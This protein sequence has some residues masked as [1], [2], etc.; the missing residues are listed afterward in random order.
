MRTANNRKR[1]AVQHGAASASAVQLDFK[2][3][4]LRATEVAAM[5][6]CCKAQAY[7]LMRTGEIPTV[8]LGRSV[9]CP[10][11][12]LLRVMEARTTGLNGGGVAKA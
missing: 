10:E 4:Y 11:S 7:R 1:A 3:R 8:K 12:A 6:G 9:R 5:L 2:E